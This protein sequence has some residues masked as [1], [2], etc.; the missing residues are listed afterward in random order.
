MKISKVDVIIIVAVIMI[1]AVFFYKAGY[2][3]PPSKGGIEVETPQKNITEERIPTPPPSLILPSRRTITGEDEG[4]HYKSVLVGREWW[5]FTAVFNDEN[6]ELKDWS[7]AISF[8][9]MAYGDLFG[10]LKPDVLMITLY[11]TN[12]NAYGG[13]VNKKRGTL[14]ATTPGVDVTFEHSWVQGQY[15]KWHVHI[16]DDEIDEQHEIKIDLDYLAHSFPLWTYDTRLLNNSKSKLANYVFIGCTV[17][18]T[19]TL[20]GET[21]MV[22]GTGNHE[23]AWSPFY[24]RRS[25]IDGWDWFHITLDNGWQMFISKFYPTPQSVTSKLSKIQPF[26]T[27]LL[28]PDGE[29]ITEFSVFDLQPEQKE[30]I[31]L[32]T[33]FPTRFTVSAKRTHNI[34]LQRI[35]LKINLDISTDNT[36]QRVWKFPT[37]VGLKVGTCKVEGTI[38]WT[39]GEKDYNLDLNGSGI[40]WTIRALP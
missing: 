11:D 15:P 5:Y 38:S 18:G 1:A 33:K 3:T 16:E 7:V 25:F 17:T 35:D 28:T 37:Y 22:K 4:C 32:F 12:G 6:S 29:S 27:L 21:F 40:T 23:H 26:G 36:Y 9:H 34:L 14:D 24:V 31:F 13:L 20:D 39:D 19:V 8:N 10:E 2:L 30:K